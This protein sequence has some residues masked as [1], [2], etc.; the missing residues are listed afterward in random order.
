M[1]LSEGGAG[2][3]AAKNIHYLI[4]CRSESEEETEK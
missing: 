1:V 4:I 2:M 3:D